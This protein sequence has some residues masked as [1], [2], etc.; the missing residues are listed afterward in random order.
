M[1]FQIGFYTEKW[2]APHH[3]LVQLLLKKYPNADH[4]QDEHC[5]LLNH[6]HGS[7]Q[8]NDWHQ[9]PES[10]LLCFG[11]PLL[12][13][14]RSQDLKQLNQA[15]LN[16]QAL[17]DA[18]GSYLLT[19]YN[20]RSKQLTLCAD[21]LAIRPFYTTEFAGGTLFANRMKPL[22]EY[23]PLTKRNVDAQ[24][25]YALLG[26]TLGEHTPYQRLRASLPGE[27]LTLTGQSQRFSRHHS[28]HHLASKPGENL[29]AGIE[30][31][32]SAFKQAVARYC[33]DD[34]HFVSTLSG[35][36]D[37]R[38]IASELRRQGKQIQSLNFSRSLTQDLWCA[39]QFADS[40]GISLEVIAVDDTQAKT[41]E[42]RLGQHWNSE[43]FANYHD[44]ERPQLVWS[45]N[46]GSV[47]VGQ[48]YTSAPLLDAIKTGDTEQVIDA[49]IAQQ[50][51][52]VPAALIDDGS[53]Q[54]LRFKERLM[55]ALAKYSTLP[56]SKAWQLFLW[57]NDQ[58]QHVAIPFE[59]MD[60]FQLDFY[61][62]FYSKG[63]LDA[64]M[65]MPM[66]AATRHGIYM[67][68]TQRHYP[69]MLTTPWQTYPEHLPCPLPKPANLQHQWQLALPKGTRRALQHQG[70]QSCLN[71]KPPLK[72]AAIAARLL[73]DQ[74][75]IR[76]ASAHL[77]FVAQYQRWR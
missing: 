13:Q 55:A 64:M 62:P 24:L 19:H 10:I 30:Q 7:W 11:H 14:N 66:E 5:F 39:Q 45:G 28:W 61:L 22:V 27:V 70:W 17:E 42:Q 54:Q 25:E 36:L 4:Y 23:A 58:H 9:T 73:A 15:Q 75:G 18:Q 56:M 53:N 29:D 60:Q 34:H 69:Q 26:Y 35:G 21:P 59:E 20:T 52:I 74:L 44:V 41:C 67:E 2:Q 72:R 37:S 46:G 43:N 31:L 77:K 65:S 8:S 63:V 51:A 57:E 38:L 33:A 1:S 48:I 40:Q 68:W 47:C 3:S 76:D 12:S 49:Y 6:S 71:G 16:V 50:Q 32:D